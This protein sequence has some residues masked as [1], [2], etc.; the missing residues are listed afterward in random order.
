MLDDRLIE[1]PASEPTPPVDGARDGT[2]PRGPRITGPLRGTVLLVLGD[3][4]GTDRI[5]PWGAR[6][7]PLAS[8]LA[9]LAGHLFAGV[10]SDFA[11][12]ARAAGQGWV[13]AGRDFGVG[14]RREEIGL[15]AVALGIRGLLARSFDPEFRSLLRRHGLLALR[16]ADELDLAAL[17]LGDEVEIPDLPDGFE[18]GKPL[19]VRNLTRGVQVAVHHDLDQAGVDEVRAGGLLAALRA[20]TASG[21]APGPSAPS[22]RDTVA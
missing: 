3:H 15:A 18:Q 22:A 7:R 16:F 4:V 8:D 14:P 19:V 5:L 20:G 12:R 1:R 9:R 13:V 11:A 2:W 21:A 6:V 10:Y 17:A